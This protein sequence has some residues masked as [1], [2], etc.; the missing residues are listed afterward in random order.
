MD[1]IF[2]PC[3]PTSKTDNW[4]NLGDAGLKTIIERSKEK[5][6][7]F[8]QI[9]EAKLATDPPLQ[10]R[11]HRTCGACYTSKEH[12]GR[13]VSKKRKNERSLSEPPPMRRRSQ[14]QEFN[15]KK[16]CI[17]CGEVCLEND[18]RHPER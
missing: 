8:H 9:I 6:D 17:L 2:A 7:N 13:K 18:S 15:F 5:G 10:L 16:Q 3:K 14:Q 4:R 12:R 1:C 11:C